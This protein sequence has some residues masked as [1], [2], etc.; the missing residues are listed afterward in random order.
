MEAD[1]RRAE[2]ESRARIRE[3]EARARAA[4]AE[5]RVAER[6]V[7]GTGGYVD[8]AVTFDLE[9]NYE[10]D[11]M[12]IWNFNQS[13]WNTGAL[14]YDDYTSRGISG[15]LIEY[16]QDGGITY[17]PVASLPLVNLRPFPLSSNIAWLHSQDLGLFNG[18]LPIVFRVTADD[19]V[20]RNSSTTSFE[21][22]Y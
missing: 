3:A 12:R 11:Q 19:G 22:A 10:L 14:D 15:A 9:G 5:A 21:I 13:I 4:E 8:E 16:S 2:A 6:A 7:L 18:W 1:A 17:H 20:T